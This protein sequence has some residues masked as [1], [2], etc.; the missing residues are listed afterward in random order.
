MKIPPRV[1]IITA[2]YNSEK[3]I[4]HTIKSVVAQSYPDIEYIIVDGGSKDST[5][6][7]IKQ[8]D[9]FVAR[10]ISEPDKGISDAWNKGIQLATGDIIGI[11]N[12]DDEY[13]ENAL[14]KAVELLSRNDSLGF[15]YGD[16]QM[17]DINGE[18]LFTQCGT[19]NYK[20]T[21]PFDMPSIPHPSVFVKREVYT[22]VG[23]FNIN[24]KTAMDYE[25]LLRMYHSGIYGGYIKHTLAK[26][27]LGGESDLNFC[28]GYKEVMKAS[29]DHGYNKHKAVALYVFK[30]TK[31]YVRRFLQH[32]GL[33]K[34]VKSYR[35]YIG[36]RYKY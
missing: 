18:G 6:S 32:Y 15:V 14:E 33:E 9:H 25:F 36:N 8:Y 2:C 22:K 21:I 3:C 13:T 19:E 1:T 7:I 17:C 10:W 34:L 29:I 30:C 31:G 20:A 4:E 16:I 28:R 11:L 24:Y 26:M 35:T 23:L 12:A 5:V 27:R